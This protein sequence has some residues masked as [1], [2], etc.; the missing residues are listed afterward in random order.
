M[1]RL[2]YCDPCH[3]EDDGENTVNR[4][5]SLM[6]NSKCFASVQV[7][8]VGN[9]KHELWKYGCLAPDEPT[10]LQVSSNVKRHP[11]NGKI[12]D[13]EHEKHK[14]WYNFLKNDQKNDHR[15]KLSCTRDYK[16]PS[17]VALFLRKFADHKLLTIWRVV[18]SYWHLWLPVTEPRFSV[19]GCT[20]AL[21]RWFRG[22]PVTV[23]S[24][25]AWKWISDHRKGHALGT[26]PL[27]PPL[28]IVIFFC[29]P[30]RTLS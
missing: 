17:L 27:D 29:T 21:H 30:K 4:T 20:L 25:T 19:G 7:E 12:A 23:S 11:P 13:Q 16:G 9:Q 10:L 14:N 1:G 3:S 24:E 5:C 8:Y 2:C 15:W 22:C 18:S 28:V 6:P 26:P